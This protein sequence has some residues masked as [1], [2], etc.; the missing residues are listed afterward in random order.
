MGLRSGVTFDEYSDFPVVY[1][2][3]DPVLVHISEP[4]PIVLV[5]LVPTRSTSRQT[6]ERIEPG[7][8]IEDQSRGFHPKRL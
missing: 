4:G 5:D 7:P 6:Q 3:L 1:S 2:G 8:T